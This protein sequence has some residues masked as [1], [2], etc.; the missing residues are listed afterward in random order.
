MK[1]DN[2]LKIIANYIHDYSYVMDVGCDHCLLGIYLCL[3]NKNI[4]V[5]A[6]DINKKPLE[7]AN[8]N[9]IKY[10]LSTRIELIQSDGL[11]NINN[12][13]DTI[14]ISGMGALTINEII[15]KSI[16]KLNNIKKII[17]C[18]NN[19]QELIRKNMNKNGF[20]IVDE[21]IVLENNIYYQI[22]VFIKEKE[23]LSYKELNY[24][25]IL[26]NRHDEIT[27][28]YYKYE[29]KK[30]K[31]II[32]SIPNKYFLKKLLLIKKIRDLSKFL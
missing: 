21:R 8:E 14:V 4:N 9:I 32:N 7:K 6:S 25:P 29:Y 19:H 17:I 10:N 22:I 16:N 20:K 1:I 3:N 28:K 11:V 31:K 27:K 18:S 24:G 15:N 2:R 26:M 23:V 5:L 12:K 13:V 30:I